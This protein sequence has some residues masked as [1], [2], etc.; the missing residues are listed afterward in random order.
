MKNI[1]KKHL[2]VNKRCLNFLILFIGLTFLSSLYASKNQTSD[3]TKADVFEVVM[4][5]IQSAHKSVNVTTMENNTT[6]YLS[7][8]QEDGSFPDISYAD[9]AQTDWTF[10]QDEE[11][12]TCLYNDQ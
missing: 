1:I 4:E 2:Y 6:Y 11:H 12:G 3:D 7:V 9:N 8:I 5:R 10:R